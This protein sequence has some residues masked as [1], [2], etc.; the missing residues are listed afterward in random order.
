MA[1]YFFQIF[2]LSVLAFAA[3][4]NAGEEHIAE[5]HSEDV[6]ITVMK[7]PPKDCARKSKRYDNVKVHYIGFLAENG[8]EFD[9]SYKR[10]EPQEFQL[11][12]GSV[13]RGWDDG[14]TGMCAGEKRK[15]IVPPKKAYGSDSGD[16]RIP[17][18]AGLVFEVEMLSVADG[19]LPPNVFK[20]LDTNN[21]GLVSKEEAL[22]YLQ[23]KASLHNEEVTDET[24]MKFVN[25]I[26]EAEDKD[27]DGFISHE[28][29]SGPKHDEL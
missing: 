19:E 29:F 9:N 20:Q 13:I 2:V 23:R 8:E 7:P 12:T 5:I 10:S 1:R 3:F 25:Q 21:D 16:E 14:L 28:E 27:G 4:T 6:V 11:G 15:L 18:N 26:F 17:A 22:D 24:H